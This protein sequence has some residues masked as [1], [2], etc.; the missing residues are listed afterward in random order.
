[1]QHLK[2][3]FAGTPPPAE[4][5]AAFN[6]AAFLLGTYFNFAYDVNVLAAWVDLSS[7]PNLLGE[8]GPSTMCAHPDSAHYPF[9]L[10]PA[11]LYRQLTGGDCVGLTSGVHVELQVNSEPS[12]PWYF[13][14]EGL[15]PVNRIDLVTVVMHEIAHGLGFLSGVAGSGAQYPFA[16][17]GFV[18][19]WYVF[20]TNGI[21]GWPTSFA[22]PVSDPCISNPLLLSNGALTFTGVVGNAS[23]E[24]FTLYSPTLFAPGSSIS[25]VNPVPGENANR[26]MYPSIQQ[27]HAW[28]DIGPDVWEAMASMGYDMVDTSFLLPFNATAVFG[29]SS[30]ASALECFF[31]S[32]L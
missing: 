4:V 22:S 31:V 29:L 17:Y 9:V 28:H 23:I 26:L 16:P 3:A 30:D 1:M 5:Q 7:V 27:G 2:I 20:Y 13:G 15:P 8:G 25:H 21:A 32:L 18:F 24:S 10:V 19:D 12:T 14:V 6:A 11:A